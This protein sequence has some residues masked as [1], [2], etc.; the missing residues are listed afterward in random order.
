MASSTV[1][2]SQHQLVLPLGTDRFE[3]VVDTVEPR[4]IFL[5][6]LLSCHF[7]STNGLYSLLYQS[8]SRSSNLPPHTHQE[9]ATIVKFYASRLES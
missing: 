8:G 3:F 9:Y 7:H 2:F 4:H 6:V 5:Q 1:G